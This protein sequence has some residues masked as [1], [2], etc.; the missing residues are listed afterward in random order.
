M[1]RNL[2]ALVVAALMLPAAAAAQED[3]PAYIRALA[4]GYKASF[5]CSNLFNGGISEQ[6]TE[7][8]DLKGTYG[9]LNPILSTLTANIDRQRRL[10]YVSYDAGLP[11][12]Y[13]VW[14]VG[15]GCTQL[16]IG[17]ML[18]SASALPRLGLTPPDLD[19]RAWPMGD[20]QATAPPS[21]NAAAI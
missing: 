2:F 20:Q 21:G 3:R 19:A 17:A 8:D 7:A 10:V 13:A 18:D 11:P 5:V 9:S 14:R 12:R 1:T 4:A 15:L 6:Q 16:P